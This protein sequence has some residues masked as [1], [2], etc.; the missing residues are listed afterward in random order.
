MLLVVLSLG[1]LWYSSE[2][3]LTLKQLSYLK[4]PASTKNDF[5]LFSGTAQEG[6]FDYDQDILYVVGK[7]IFYSEFWKGLYMCFSI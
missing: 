5:R 2:A 3:A 4:L 7:I 6:S 1:L